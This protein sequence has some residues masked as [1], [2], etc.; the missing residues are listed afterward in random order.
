MFHARGRGGQSTVICGGIE[1]AQGADQPRMV[2]PAVDHSP[3]PQ[4][5][6][7]VGAEADSFAITDES[8]V[9]TSR[10]LEQAV[11]LPAPD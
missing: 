8:A 7:S 3:R 9:R 2:K 4:T 6:G 11:V 10:I 5:L 1:K